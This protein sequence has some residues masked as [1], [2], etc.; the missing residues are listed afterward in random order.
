[1]YLLFLEKLKLIKVHN[2][3][4]VDTKCMLV[5]QYE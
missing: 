5:V 4:S 2:F 3:A 1:M